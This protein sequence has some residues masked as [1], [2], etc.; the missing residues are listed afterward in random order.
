MFSDDLVNWL[1][2]GILPRK[3]RGLLIDVGAYVGEFTKMCIEAGLIKRAHLFEANPINFQKLSASF[4]LKKNISIHNVALGSKNCISRFQCN[5]DLSTGS[6]LSYS[7]INSDSIKTCLVKQKTLDLWWD[8][9]NRPFVDLIKSDTQGN[10]L[11][12]MRGAKNLISRCRPWVIIEVI[13]TPLYIK[14]AKPDDVFKFFYK[15][16]YFLAGVF[17]EHRSKNNLIAFAD[18]VFSPKKN[19]KKAKHFLGRPK[20]SDILNENINL[21]KVCDE[22]LD[23]INQLHSAVH[24][25]SFSLNEKTRKKILNKIIKKMLLLLRKIKIFRG[26]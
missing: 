16:K 12:V 9:N 13:F 7:G 19:F 2:N 14:Q 11:N 15:R 18:L 3:N 21:K 10:D 6:I 1:K 4:P 23:L 22:R 5:S 20:L 8:Q 25:K 17:N 26:I 24:K